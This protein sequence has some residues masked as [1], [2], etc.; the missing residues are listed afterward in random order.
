M[1]GINQLRLSVA[2]FPRRS[3]SS[4]DDIAG[5]RLRFSHV[6]ITASQGESKS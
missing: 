1:F 3:T 2:A 5:S 6:A 4:L